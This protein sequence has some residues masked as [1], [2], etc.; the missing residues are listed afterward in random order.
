MRRKYRL[1]EIQAIGLNNGESQLVYRAEDQLV[2]NTNLA[3]QI[4][5]AELLRQKDE[6]KTLTRLGL[7]FLTI[8]RIKFE[9]NYV[10]HI[11]LHMLIRSLLRRL[12]SL[13]YFH[14]GWELELDFTGL[15]ERAAE[16]RL[17]KDGT[18]WVD[19]ERYSSRQDNKVNMGGLVGRVEYE[20]YLDEFL[21]LLRLG[22]LVHVGKG[23]VF[24]MGKYKVCI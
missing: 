19:W 13:A 11:E 14:H 5:Q 4:D 21:P 8:T 22:E 16:V 7:D 24:G 12:S 17:V 18:R 1:A 6:D 20:G 2:R 10:H 9:E 23:A 3:I 15:I